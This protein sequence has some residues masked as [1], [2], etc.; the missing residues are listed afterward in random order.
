MARRR[1]KLLGIVLV[2]L[3]LGGLAAGAWLF[4]ARWAPSRAQYPVQGVYLDTHE[5]RATWPTMKATG[6]DFAYLLATIGSDGRD[7]DFQRRLAEAKAAGVR[8]GAVHR[9]DLCRLAGDQAGNFITNVPRGRDMLPPVIEMRFL[10]S[11]KDRPGRALVLSEI[12]ALIAQIENHSGKPAVIK[13]GKD[14]EAMYDISTAVNR[15]VWLQRDFFPPDYAA[16][17]FVMWT[18]N[19]KRDVEGLE[20]PGNWVVVRP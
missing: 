14:F 7:Q 19:E 6:V 17:P 4:A 1:G 13:L 18:A 9:F 5:E 12:A 11:C 3:V 2:L 20:G 8:V 10:D 15:T 16:R